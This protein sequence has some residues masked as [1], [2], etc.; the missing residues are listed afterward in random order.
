MTVVGAPEANL[1][2]AIAPLAFGE[3]HQRAAA[4]AD[5]RFTRYPQPRRGFCRDEAHPSAEPG[6]QAGIRIGQLDTHTQRAALRVGFRQQRIHAPFQPLRAGGQRNLDA[7][8]EADRARLRFGHRHLEPD[9]LETVDPGDRSTRGKGHAFAHL[10]ALQ[11]STD[12]CADALAQLHLAVLFQSANALLGHA[13]QLQA[14]TRGG[15]Q[16]GMA[17]APQ[18]EILLL[19]GGPFRHQQLHQRRAGL[20]DIARRVAIDPFDEAC[21][22]RLHLGHIATTQRQCA[23]RFDAILDRATL[24]PSQAH[25]KVLRHPRID[26][27]HLLAGLVLGVARHQLHVHEGRRAGLVE[28]LLRVHGVVP[29]EHFAP[30]AGDRP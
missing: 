18:G 3:H 25:A 17:T 6:T 21:D 29:V 14:A 11:Q 27:Q 24:D 15:G 9:A 19:G 30:I 1:L 7:L 23:L 22:P 2:W 12:R 4:S 28:A 8:A 16:I 5:D 26:L 13:C 10:Q 20:D